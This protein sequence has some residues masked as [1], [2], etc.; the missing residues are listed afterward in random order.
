MEGALLYKSWSERRTETVLCRLCP[1][2]YH[3]APT[4]RC[5]IPDSPEVPIG[6]VTVPSCDHLVV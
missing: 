2:T 1:L 6:E 3:W 5:A 4:C